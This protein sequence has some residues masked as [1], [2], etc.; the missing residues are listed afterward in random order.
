M[1]DKRVEFE[2]LK[3]FWFAFLH[4]H[5]RISVIVHTIENR[6]VIGPEKIPVLQACVDT[7]QPGNFT[8]CGSER[9]KEKTLLN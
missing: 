9:V 4:W 3:S 1:A 2:I 6:F 5:E 8:G 7:F